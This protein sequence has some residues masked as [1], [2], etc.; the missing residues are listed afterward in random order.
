MVTNDNDANR[1]SAAETKTIADARQ[2][3][4]VK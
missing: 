3:L 1:R 4:G 2:G